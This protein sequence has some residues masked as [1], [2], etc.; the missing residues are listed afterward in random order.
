MLGGEDVALQDY[1]TG[2]IVWAGNIVSADDLLLKNR[3]DF[4]IRAA[5]VF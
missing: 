5:K 2:N 1:E 4:R 3:H